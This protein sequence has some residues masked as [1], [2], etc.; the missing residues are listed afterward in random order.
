MLIEQNM[1]NL[2]ISMIKSGNEVFARS[3]FLSLTHTH[4]YTLH[5]LVPV[6]NIGQLFVPMELKMEQTLK[7]GS[8][9]T[10]FG[11]PSSFALG[12]T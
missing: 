8:F 12:G 11:I 7:F 5:T 3:L 9:P 4:I 2:A 10:V 1:I 6:L